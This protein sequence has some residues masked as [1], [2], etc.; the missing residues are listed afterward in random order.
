MFSIYAFV[1]VYLDVC[2]YK[3]VGV[4][5][6]YVWFCMC[7]L[8]L[9]FPWRFF[10]KKSKWSKKQKK[11][12]K[13]NTQK[14]EIFFTSFPFPFSKLIKLLVFPLIDV[15]I[16][17]VVLRI[18]ISKVVVIVVVVVV[19]VVIV[20]PFLCSIWNRFVK[21]VT[22]DCY[23]SAFLSLFFR[24]LYSIIYAN[25]SPLSS[26]LLCTRDDL[27]IDTVFFFYIYIKLRTIE[28]HQFITL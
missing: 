2:L 20:R 3:R 9:L 12:A 22:R 1:C 13:R 15:V 11:I 25:T 21:F 18:A 7:K 10:F 8:L 17:V 4:N 26:F 24:I 16:V 19:L 14:I 23:W 28:H 5:V 6:F 27:H